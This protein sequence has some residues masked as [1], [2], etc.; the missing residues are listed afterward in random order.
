MEQAGIA[1]LRLV[2]IMNELREKCPWDKKQTIATLRHLTIEETYELADAI[3]ENNYEDIKEELGDLLLHIVFYAKIGEEQKQFTLTDAINGICEKLIIRH[4]HI[5][6]DVVVQ[7]DED[8]KQNWE[9]I[10]LA[11]GKKSVL[12]GVPASLPAMVKAIRLQ[13]KSRQVGFEWEETAQVWDKLYEEL[14][15]VKQAIENGDQTEIED[16]MGDLFF[17]MVNLSRYLNVDAENALEKT[18]KKFMKRF[19]FMEAEAQKTDKQLH[20]MTL[21]EMEELWRQAKRQ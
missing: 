3:T 12:G 10:K 2:N 4:P 20:N 1:F 15:E 13:D 17:S 19:N 8:V 14:G 18:N 9:K 21:A 7:N 5:Y 11:S 6:A 16:E